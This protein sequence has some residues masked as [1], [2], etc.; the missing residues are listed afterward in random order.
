[1]QEAFLGSVRSIPPRLSNTLRLCA[2]VYIWLLAW[3]PRRSQ[4]WC[5][6]SCWVAERTDEESKYFSGRR[7]SA[8]FPEKFKQVKKG[9]G[10]L[11]IGRRIFARGRMEEREGVTVTPSVLEKD[12]TYNMTHSDFIVTMERLGREKE[13]LKYA[14]LQIYPGLKLG[15]EVFFPRADVVRGHRLVL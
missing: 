8:P 14:Y 5:S 3:N 11:Q 9:E 1:M 6:S 15:T 4:V 13:N 2:L 7:Y 12:K 10:W